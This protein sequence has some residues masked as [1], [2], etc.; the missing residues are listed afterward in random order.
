M[1]HLLLQ[2]VGVL[3]SAS[4]FGFWLISA[5]SPLDTLAA[6]PSENVNS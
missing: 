5:I 4:R 3:R 6:H 2:T 1:Q